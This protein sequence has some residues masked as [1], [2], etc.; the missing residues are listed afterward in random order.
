MCIGEAGHDVTVYW[1]TPLCQ[2]TQKEGCGFKRL[3]FGT[4]PL[5]FAVLGSPACHYHVKQKG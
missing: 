4:R 5:T 3:H 1:A 2:F